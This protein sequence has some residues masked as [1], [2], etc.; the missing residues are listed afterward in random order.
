MTNIAIFASGSGSNAENIIHYFEGRN[1]IKV[2]LILTNNPTAHVIERG[3]KLGIPVITFTKSEF[4]QTTIIQQILNDAE[5]NYIVLAGF[6][7]LVPKNIIDKYEGH[8]VNIHPA[9]LPKHCGRGMYGDNVHRS[10]KEAGEKESGIT[11]H[12]VNEK[13]DCGDIIFQATCEV[14]DSDTPDDI[15]NK[16]HTLEYQYFPEVIDQH[17]STL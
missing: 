5:I 3:K 6:L 2:S 11:I 8:I 4:N 9:L 10:V 12:H 7:L 13:F 17:I 15:A 14:L 1:D 16:V